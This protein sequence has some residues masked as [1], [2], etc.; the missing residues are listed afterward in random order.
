MINPYI[1][2][3]PDE[4]EN[5]IELMGVLKNGTAKEKEHALLNIALGGHSPKA[6]LDLFLCYIIDPELEVVAYMC[7]DKFLENYR[8]YPL[9]RVL[10][11]LINGL[12]HPKETIKHYCQNALDN[13]VIPGKLKE[14]TLSFE[15]F[16]ISFEYDSLKSYLHSD[17]AEQIIIALLYLYHRP[18]ANEQLFKVL[19]EQLTKNIPAVTCVVGA[20]IDTKLAN[21]IEL[22]NGVGELSL[23]T[24]TIARASGIKSKAVWV[25]DRFDSIRELAREHM[26]VIVAEEQEVR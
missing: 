19:N 26:K 11:V 15:S 16:Q 14:E 5:N 9:D 6:V 21:I 10:P 3:F 7:I 4:F 1:I 25:Y 8:Q 18:H 17:S 2:K 12:N 20:I 13:L 24:Y 23:A 22:I